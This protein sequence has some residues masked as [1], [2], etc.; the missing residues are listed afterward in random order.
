MALTQLQTSTEP[1]ATEVVLAALDRILHSEIFGKA[2]SLRH[3]LQYIVVQTLEGHPEQIK[4]SIIAMDVFS[5]RSDFDGRIDNIVRV[6]AHRLRKLLE[7]YYSD[8]GTGETLRITVPKGS[9]VPQFEVVPCSRFTTEAVIPV[10]VEPVQATSPVIDNRPTRWWWIVAAF[11]SGI[12]VSAGTFLFVVLPRTVPIA[13][14]PASVKEIWG[15]VFD[16]ASKVIVSYSN[17]VFLRVGRLPMLLRYLGPLSAPP[18]AVISLGENDRYIDTKL[19]PKGQELHFSDSWTGTGE[20]LA[21][22]RLTVLSGE[23]RHAMTVTPSRLLS[24]NEMRGANVIFV[25]SP[26]VNGA[27]AEIGVSRQPIYSA[28]NGRIVIRDPKPGEPA[29]FAG[30]ENEVTRELLAAYT[31]VSMLPGIDTGHTVLSSAGTN[32]AGTWA[33]IDFATSPGGSAQLVRALKAI[34]GGRMPRLYQAVIRTEI[35]KGTASNPSL[36]AVRVANAQ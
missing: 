4:E 31:L 22:N 23:F 3:L 29:S 1:I 12:A 32:T 24:L 7:T 14:V 25:G 26:V 30:A 33:G 27:L 6:Q 5:R 15:P 35:I 19:V 13:D 20:V 36:V 18:G 16:P 9:Y 2:P 28:D 8:P 21:V 17:P 34:N 11:L 10:E